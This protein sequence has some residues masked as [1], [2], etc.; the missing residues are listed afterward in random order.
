MSAFELHPRLAADTAEVCDLA[1]C[2]LVVMRDARFA[3][4]ILVPRRAGVREVHDLV[5]S[6]QALLMGEAARVAARI[7]AWPGVTK[8]N[9]GALGNLVPQ[10]HWHV[11]GRS[12]SDAAWPGP[13]WGSGPAVEP[14]EHWLAALV[15][16]LR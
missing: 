5:P 12:P 16:H 9:H 2:R 15:S 7:A 4:A 11:V 14:P 3:W 13:V 6:D 1:L 8:I 10:L